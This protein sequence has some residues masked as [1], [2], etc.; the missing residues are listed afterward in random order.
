MLSNDLSNDDNFVATSSFDWPKW[1]SSSF[2]NLSTSPPSPPE[3]GNSNLLSISEPDAP[4][5]LS[6]ATAKFSIVGLFLYDSW[7]YK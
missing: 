6:E 1:P 7:F 2:F 3:S 5:A 4:K